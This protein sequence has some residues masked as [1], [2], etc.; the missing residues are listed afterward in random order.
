MAWSV[1]G[2]YFENCNCESICPCT[3]SAMTKPATNDRCRVVLAFHIDRGDI[4][5]VD[6]SGLSFAMVV[7]SPPLMSEG[8]WR[9]GLV[10]DSAA[11]EE[12]A[13]ALGRVLGGDLGGP[14][15]M[16]ASLTGEMLGIEQA[17]ADWRQSDG[18]FAARF[19]DLIDI[20]VSSFVA[21]EMAEPVRLTNVF[22]PAA[23]TLTVSPAT[24]SKVDAFGISFDGAGLAGFN[25]PYAW[26]G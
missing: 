18:T 22:H 25:A 3:W 16:I 19:G 2:S 8:G 9:L 5:G 6:V 10:T 4:E 24:R 1:E 14:P 11:S 20:E 15:A 21:G 13:G 7:D 26:S 17:A 12:Q 23:T